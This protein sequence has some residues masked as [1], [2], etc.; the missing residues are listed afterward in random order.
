M[1]NTGNKQVREEGQSISVSKQRCP[2]AFAISP[3]AGSNGKRSRPYSI[4]TRAG[5]AHQE[6]GVTVLFQ[7]RLPPQQG[8]GALGKHSLVP[9]D[10]SLA[11]VFREVPLQRHSG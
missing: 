10:S 6:V 5:C 3:C 2:S 4:L 8:E 1:E 11:R 7:Q 9:G